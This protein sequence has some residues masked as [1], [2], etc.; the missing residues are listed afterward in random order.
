[1]DISSVKIQLRPMTTADA[2]AGAE[3]VKKI[4]WSQTPTTWEQTIR[5]S[6]GG[7]FCLTA[8]DE[9]IATVIIISYGTKLAWIG[10]VVTHPDFRRQGLAQRM[11][12][13]GLDYARRRGIQTVMLDASSMGFPLYVKLGFQSLY[14]VDVFEGIANAIDTTRLSNSVRSIS[15][16]DLPGIVNLDKQLFG[17]GRTMMIADLVESGQGWVTGESGNIDGYLIAKPSNQSIS[18]GPWYHENTDGAEALFKCAI[19][20]HPGAHFKVHSPEPNTA[21]RAIIERYGLEL[22]RSVT[23]MVL[24]GKPPGTMQLQYSVAA[25]ATG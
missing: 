16:E 1:M 17:E 23:R 3:L 4:G 25:L 12:E 2:A 10:M 13:V 20:A 5:W 15:A 8:D 19:A 21:A 22:N 24:G 6:N 14:K 11:M 18:I 9:I 7:S